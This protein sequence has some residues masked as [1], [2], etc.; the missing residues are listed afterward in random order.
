MSIY[1]DF[2]ILVLGIFLV[3]F[4]SAGLFI[5]L[6][7]TTIAMKHEYL[8]LTPLN[9]M[10]QNLTGNTLHSANTIKNNLLSYQNST[11]G[12]KILY[13]DNWIVK[14]GHGNVSAILSNNDSRYTGL[15]VIV[16]RLLKN[17]TLDDYLASHLNQLKNHFEPSM[18]TF[19]VIKS[20]PIITNQGYPS[21]MIQYRYACAPDLSTCEAFEGWMIK[22]DKIYGFKV[23]TSY[24]SGVNKFDQQFLASVQKIIDSTQID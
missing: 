22:N 1:Y 14:P 16:D 24:L 8:V 17:L 9:A 3:V 13:P 23:E 11:A 6:Y 20:E 2:V 21:V 19:S 7:S 18:G 10:A 5:L 15:K 4:S 12:I